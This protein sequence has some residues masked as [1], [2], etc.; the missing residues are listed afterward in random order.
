VTLLVVTADDFGVAVAVNEAVELAHERGILTAASLMVAGA[1]AADAVERARR[2]PRL[3]VG[4]HL[5]ITQG[6]PILPIDQVPDLVNADG[7]FHRNLGRV[8]LRVATSKQVRMQ[9][10]AEID[11]QFAAFVATGLVFDHVNAH[12]HFHVHPIIAGMVLEA[13]SRHGVMAIR[14]PVEPGRPGGSGWLAAPFA[15]SLRRRA[16]RRGL[17]VPDQV[18]GLAASGRMTADAIRGAVSKLHGG[19]NELY[20]HPATEDDFVG[21]GP[22]YLHRAELSGLL[23]RTC[24]DAIRR[25]GARLGSFSQYHG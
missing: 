20:L 15:R 8:G 12:E 23:D 10:R 9:M 24:M 5:D 25:S 19:V 2:M 16:R 13:A 4:L 11:A 1:A 22:G 14:A 18:F 17:L 7:R 21:H 3:G 6:R